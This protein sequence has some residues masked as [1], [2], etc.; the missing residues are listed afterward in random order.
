MVD[1]LRIILLYESDFNFNNKII[2]RKALENGE[3]HGA[4]AIEQYGSRRGKSAIDQ[5]LN[6]QLTYDIWRQSR[7]PGILISNDAKSCY[8][9]MVHSAI[10]LALQRMGIQQGPIESMLEAIQ[11][12]K[13]FVRTGHG[14][15]DEFFDCSELTIPCQGSGQGNG[16]G[17]SIW[18]LL[19]TPLF[20]L[21]RAKDFGA[22]FRSHVTRELFHTT[23]F[24]FV[25][26]TDLIQNGRDG[27]DDFLSICN[28]MQDTM[29][30]WAGALKVTGGA[31][32]QK[33][34]FWYGIEFSWEG[35]RWSYARH[36]NHSTITFED[37]DGN[38]QTLQ[39]LSTSTASET[40]GVF[41][42]PDGNSSKQREQMRNVSVT[43]RDNIRSGFLNK[44]DAW[45]AMNT[46][47]L[48]TL[49]YPLP[50]LT[51]SEKEC[52]H[53]MAPVL[54]AALSAAGYNN[55]FPRAVVYGPVSGQGLGV[56][57]LYTTQC[58]SHVALIIQH[59]HSQSV[60]GHLLRH[61]FELLQL[62][63][64]R[65]RLPLESYLTKRSNY[66]TKSWLQFTWQFLTDNEIKLKTHRD[67]LKPSRVNDVFLMDEFIGSFTVAELKRINECRMHLRALT[68]SDI[69]G[70]T[71]N[72]ITNKA[73]NGI[74]DDDRPSPY[75]WPAT[76]VP[77]E[78]DWAL[79]KK[80]L[81][82]LCCRSNILQTPLGEWMSH[83][84]EHPWKFYYIRARDYIIE[85]DGDKWKVYRRYRC[86]G[87]PRNEPVYY[88]SRFRMDS[89]PP[90]KMKCTI[91]ILPQD[92]I[93][94]T[95]ATSTQSS[96]S[97]PPPSQ[98][99]LRIR[100][101]KSWAFHTILGATRSSI[102]HL[103]NAIRTSQ[104]K[105]VS[106]GSFYSEFKYGSSATVFDTGTNIIILQNTTPGRP[107]EQ[108]SYRSELAG[109]YSFLLFLHQLQ[110]HFK[111]R[112][113][114]IEFACDN[115]SAL[116][117]SFMYDNASVRQ[118]DYDLLSGIHSLRSK[119]NITIRWSHVK[120][121]QDDH[122][123]FENLS[124]LSKLNVKADTFAKQ[125]ASAQNFQ[126]HH[127][128]SIEGEF[129]CLLRPDGTKFVSHVANEL[130]DHIHNL[131][132]EEH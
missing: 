19:S 6:K 28:S 57:N 73:W 110:L 68:L 93:L 5:V 94:L 101:L 13:H 102:P 72:R 74:Q 116:K 83:T 39:R 33:K 58:A 3:R 97:L 98:F 104:A 40:L 96:R 52:N 54:E 27:A 89:A 7:R 15:S 90:L 48:K 106:D 22:R 130:H 132:L 123:N 50:A 129:C 91:K 30:T 108:S 75:E 36:E 18:A 21:M 100:H 79:W 14:D 38:T 59:F 42:A 34:S 76:G 49:Q 51:L 95:G 103:V 84:N 88:L 70:G 32:D 113:G 120:S 60:T 128:G 62:E 124:H 45:H 81:R 56:K 1:K 63:W 80:A 53:I 46:T 41:L 126:G 17:P 105:A 9:R 125:F 85:S 2:G 61:S 8:D 47:V 114:E 24:A 4:I 118:N 35:V 31:L 66:V 55:S 117:E 23:G 10:S 77:T 65:K 78:K 16:A 112:Q 109:I 92:K 67:Q 86:Q 121:H 119:L 69:T 99:D 111:I 25:D 11:K 107:D 12:L 29:N 43:F 122:I 82:R 71:G 127:Q 20:D 37:K 26:D 64:G 131:Q 44:T 115:K 87:R